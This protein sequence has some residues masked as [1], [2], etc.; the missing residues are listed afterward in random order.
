METN[1]EIERLIDI[2]LAE[3]LGTSGDITTMALLQ[4][5][6]FSSGKLVLREKAVVAGLVYLEAIFKKIDPKLTVELRVDEGSYQKAGTV[7]AKIS[8][9]AR[10]ILAGERTALNFLQY[11]SGVA[12]IISAYVN[13][14]K[15]LNCQILD[16]RKT[17]PGLRALAQYAHVL[18]GGVI[19]RLGLNQRFIIKS[20][21]LAFFAFESKKPIQEAV[22]KVRAYL[23]DIPI[24]VEVFDI[25]QVKEALQTDCDSIMLDNL[26]P[27]EISKC[28]RLIRKTPKKVY[29]E[30]KGTITLETVRRFAE[31]GV[32][33][34][35]ISASYFAKPTD[36]RLRLMI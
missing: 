31:T 24:E 8:G 12:T 17:L 15:G 1:P 9:P 22:K 36:I 26:P 25:S 30:S 35:A 20:P 18:V 32:D 11:A 13:K 16:T 6:T 10:S 19:H 29:L 4:E 21:H 33:G 7:I 23:P 27:D 34:I 28:L 3:D 14:V 2:A 5:S